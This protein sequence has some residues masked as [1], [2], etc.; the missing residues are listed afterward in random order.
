M[1]N[2]NM[3]CNNQL[4]KIPPLPVNE[5][6]PLNGIKLHKLGYHCFPSIVTLNKETNLENVTFYYVSLFFLK[7]HSAHAPNALPRF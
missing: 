6:K 3:L 1:K 5:F 7:D 4:Y 2:K